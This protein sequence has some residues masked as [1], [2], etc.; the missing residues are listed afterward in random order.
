MTLAGGYHV[1]HRAT[2][3]S[4]YVALASTLKLPS[5]CACEPNSASGV[6]D[7]T[8]PELFHG[9][10]A[11]LYGCDIGVIWYEDGKFG[12]AYHTFS[13][14]AA[15]TD[16]EIPITT[17][18]GKGDTIELRT[19]LSGQYLVAQ[20]YK[21]SAWKHTS[22]ISLTSA[23]A[24]RFAQGC[25]INREICMASNNAATGGIPSAAY[26]RDTKFSNSTLTTTSGTYTAMSNSNSTLLAA[27]A[28]NRIIDSRR[29]G[30]NSGTT[31]GFAWDL[32]SCDFR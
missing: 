25:K 30:R 24:T 10:Y 28:D 5:S 11:G 16:D 8:Y 17:G 2:N 13:N 29:Y 21:N 32:G 27:Y 3:T 4:S 6:Y 20:I 14:T 26:F 1:C 22:Q 23:A 9:F 7:G 15:V 18:V 19:Y 31:N 12:I